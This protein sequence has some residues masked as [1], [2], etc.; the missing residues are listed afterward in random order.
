MCWE[1]EDAMKDEYRESKSRLW[2]LQ[3]AQKGECVADCNSQWKLL[4][5]QTLENNNSRVEEFSLAV[6]NLLVKGRAKMRNILIAGPANCA[7]TFLIKPLCT[8]FHVFVSPA[9]GT[10]N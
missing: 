10:F 3:D 7:K 9:K 5:Q 6:T 8:I 4:A 1:M 2:L